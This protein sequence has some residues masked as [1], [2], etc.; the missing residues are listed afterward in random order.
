MRG[1][2]AKQ[3][4]LRYR[5]AQIMFGACQPAAGAIKHA[6]FTRQHHNRNL[7]EPRVLFYQ[8]AGLVPVEPRHHEIHKNDI[9]CLSLDHAQRS[10]PVDRSQYYNTARI[11]DSLHG[12]AHRFA[13]VD[14]QYSQCFY[15]IKLF[16]DACCNR[17]GGCADRLDS[18]S[19]FVV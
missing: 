12:A 8:P 4:L 2:C 17:P 15:R 7:P 9:G 14:N 19:Y 11:Q 13:I 3:I 5:F 10:Y 6:V 1:D 16:A 18:D